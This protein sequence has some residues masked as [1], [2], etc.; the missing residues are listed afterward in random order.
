MKLRKTPPTR[1]LVAVVWHG[2]FGAFISGVRGW[3]GDY[4]RLA[5]RGD[6]IDR[7]VGRYLIP[8]FAC[9]VV[10]LVGDYL[11]VVMSQKLKEEPRRHQQQSD[12][13]EKLAD[14]YLAASITS[15]ND[16]VWCDVAGH[17]ERIDPDDDG[18]SRVENK[19]ELLHGFI[20]LP[21]VNVD[22]SADEKTPTQQTNE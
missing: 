2:L 22:A 19:A 6:Q 13:Q 15:K 14:E 7:V 10:W 5:L 1:G 4:V 11:V 12:V 8:G 3:C 16:P 9:L 21:N 17:N 18:S 20:F